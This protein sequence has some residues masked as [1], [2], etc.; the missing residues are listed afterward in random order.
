MTVQ[1]LEK[2]I[3]QLNPWSSQPKS[4]IQIAHPLVL[5]AQPQVITVHLL[6]LTAQTQVLTAHALALI[7]YPLCPHSPLLG[8]YSPLPASC[9]WPQTYHPEMTS[10]PPAPICKQATKYQTPDKVIPMPQ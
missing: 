7:A 2:D 3:S 1:K 6:V 5:I 10:N 9:C 4:Q 8:P